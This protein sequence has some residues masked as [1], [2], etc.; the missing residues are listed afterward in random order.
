MIWDEKI[1][2]FLLHFP[3]TFV[4]HCHKNETLLCSRNFAHKTKRRTCPLLQKWFDSVMEI[5]MDN[6]VFSNL[7]KTKPKLSNQSFLKSNLYNFNRKSLITNRIS[8]EF[9]RIYSNCHVWKREKFG[10]RVRQILTFSYVENKEA[11]GNQLI[12]VSKSKFARRVKWHIINILKQILIYPWVVHIAAL[13]FVWAWQMLNYSD[14]QAF[15][16]RVCIFGLSEVM[17]HMAL[18]PMWHHRR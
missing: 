15:L 7:P 3:S 2:N 12:V 1:K 13:V 14:A 4:R 5:M 9:G 16:S 8:Y 18:S 11:V 10:K 6:Q 17:N